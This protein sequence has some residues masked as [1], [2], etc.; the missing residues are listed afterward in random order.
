MGAAKI[1]LSLCRKHLWK[2]FPARA[3]ARRED[4]F[5]AKYRD[6]CVGKTWRPIEQATM[7]Y[8]HGISVETRA[9]RACLNDIATDAR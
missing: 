7:A 8:G 4:G 6:G 3:S 1:A 5:P 9:T 2:C